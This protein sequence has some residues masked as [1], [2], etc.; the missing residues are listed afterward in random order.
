MPAQQRRL[1]EESDSGEMSGQ[2]ASL[3]DIPVPRN[4]TDLPVSETLDCQ[5]SSSTP[6]SSSVLPASVSVPCV[7]R[8]GLSRQ[9]SPACMLHKPPIAPRNLHLEPATAAEKAAASTA[10][11][12]RH[13]RRTA[14]VTPVPATDVVLA[15][16]VECAASALASVLPIHL[17]PSSPV[18]PSYRP[19]M[20]Q[21]LKGIP[22]LPGRSS[23]VSKTPSSRI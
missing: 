21:A 23:S 19:Q 7:Q 22:Q 13:E 4:Q 15:A 5:P 16:P 12:L 10:R 18:R 9:D 3:L 20:S 6:A 2:H 17:P 11:S 8:A 14:T 1:W